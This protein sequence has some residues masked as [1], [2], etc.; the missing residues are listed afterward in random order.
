[1]A[2]PGMPPPGSASCSA[3]Q[4][5]ARSLAACPAS[6]SLPD[7]CRTVTLL[8]QCRPPASGRACPLPGFPRRACPLLASVRSRAGPLSHILQCSSTSGRGQ[9]RPSDESHPPAPAVPPPGFGRGMPPPGMPP[10]GGAP[11]PCLPTR[12][13]LRGPS[14]L[15]YLR[16]FRLTAPFAVPLPAQFRR[17]ASGRG[18]RLR[19]ALRRS[20]ARRASK[21]AWR[22]G[23]EGRA[24]WKLLLLARLSIVVPRHGG[25]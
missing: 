5:R 17:L 25:A 3:L 6:P 19:A 14:S 13:S 18:C 20:T 22:G 15:F 10:P 11:L 4:L 16:Q 2:P 24:Q 9:T 8:P 12:R 1:M 21:A 23:E 7:S